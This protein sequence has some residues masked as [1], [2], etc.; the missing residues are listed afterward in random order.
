MEV[1]VVFYLI[2][3]ALGVPFISKGD[4]L[5]MEWCLGRQKVQGGEE[6][7]PFM[8]VLVCLEA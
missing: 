8:L 4:P 3:C 7:G 1:V 2:Q 5:G 6:S